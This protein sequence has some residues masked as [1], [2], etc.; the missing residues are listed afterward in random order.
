MV[1]RPGEALREAALTAEDALRY[2]HGDAL[3]APEDAPRGYTLMT[4]AGC[5]LGFAK[6][7]DGLYK[8]RYPKGLRR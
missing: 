6:C 2:Q 4:L 1:L 3:P 5:P 7:S 8:N